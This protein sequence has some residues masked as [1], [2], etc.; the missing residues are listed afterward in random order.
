VVAWGAVA[1]APCGLALAQLDGTEATLLSVS[2]IPEQRQQGFA[3]RLLQ[4]LEV[5]L[6]ELGATTLTGTYPLGKPTTPA[7][8]RLL[9]RAGWGEAKP[10]M[11]LFTMGPAVPPGFLD[12]VWVKDTPFPDGYT[13]RTWGVLTPAERHA[14]ST[15]VKAEQHPPFTDPFACTDEIDPR[16]SLILEHDGR[17]VGWLI[18]HRV[19]PTTVRVA[20][21]YADSRV[22]PPGV[23]RQLA[24]VFARMWAADPPQLLTWIIEG[25]N[26]FLRVCAGRMLRGMPFTLVRTVRRTKRLHHHPQNVYNTKVV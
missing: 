19:S 24:G 10:R 8:E 13:V 22:V 21:L 26:P 6:R 4:S 18:V 3:T 1:D 17:V 5:R 15:Q 14:I 9:S 7:V 2:V 12:L 16:Y 11:G 20:I 23:G 25:E